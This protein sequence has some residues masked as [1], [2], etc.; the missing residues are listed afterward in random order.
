MKHV[1]LLRLERRW[2]ISRPALRAHR[3]NHISPAL[4]ALRTE[5]IASRVRNVADRVEDLVRETDAM[6]R[7]AKKATRMPLALKAVHEQGDNYELLA[8]ITG[9]L[10][11]RP[12]GTVN[13]QQSA[14]FIAVRSVIFEVVEQHPELRREI[15]RRL[16]ALAD[17]E[18]PGATFG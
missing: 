9:E 4:K 6:Y 8:K 17:A 10:D 12:Q 1:P 7:S 5:R 13:I 15:S 16:R 14:A 3:A 2:G 18:P 11:D